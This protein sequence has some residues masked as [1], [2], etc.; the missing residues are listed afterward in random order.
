MSQQ[1][2]R[3]RNP[4]INPQAKS[5]QWFR[6][7]VCTAILALSSLFVVT[8]VSA[9]P[10]FHLFAG[11]N[12][13]PVHPNANDPTDFRAFSSLW[14][15]TTTGAGFM[16]GRITFVDGFVLPTTNTSQ[17]VTFDETDIAEFSFS[18]SQS[19]FG[20]TPIFPVFSFTALASDIVSASGGIGHDGTDFFIFSN[21]GPS[22]MP[23]ITTTIGAT[24]GGVFGTP[25]L[26]GIWDMV[27]ATSLNLVGTGSDTGRTV[28]LQGPG[29]RYELT[30][31]TASSAPA[32]EPSSIL[33]LSTGL[34]G[35]AVR[36]RMK[37]R[38]QTG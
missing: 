14:G 27:G 37:K 3:V 16:D 17:T 22:G 18:H 29:G 4:L 26:T 20:S 7:R 9:G 31:S 28:S 5:R 10:I 38:K 33:L 21:G 15:I 30:G 6:S 35:L 36:R 24:I 23:T 32:P 12:G 13:T 8:S 11:N 1:S 25:G 2:V 19:A 34:A